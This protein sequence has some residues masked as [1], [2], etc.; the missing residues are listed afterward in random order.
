MSYIKHLP[1]EMIQMKYDEYRE[2]PKLSTPLPGG[3]A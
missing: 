2:V 3:L 1:T